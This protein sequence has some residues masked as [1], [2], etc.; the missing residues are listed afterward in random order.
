MEYAPAPPFDSGDP[1]HA[2]A[3]VVSDV[4]ERCAPSLAQ[5]GAVTARV[6]ERLKLN[7]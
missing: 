6:A 2:P 4:R 5:R 1:A 3:A 7:A